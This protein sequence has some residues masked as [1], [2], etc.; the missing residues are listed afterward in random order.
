MSAVVHII[1]GRWRGALAIV[2][3]ERNWGVLAYMPI[4]QDGALGVE[5]GVGKAY[6][7]LAS[8]EY[9]FVGEINDF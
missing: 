3:E 2:E 8:D 9:R 1:G 6:V 4:P 7:R 5:D